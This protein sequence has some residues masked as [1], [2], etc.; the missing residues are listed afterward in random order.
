MPGTDAHAKAVLHFLFAYVLPRLHFQIK[1]SANL[2]SSWKCLI[3]WEA[4]RHFSLRYVQKVGIAVDVR[5]API[6]RFSPPLALWV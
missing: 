4:R 6:I 2:Y 5:K 3:A 1:H